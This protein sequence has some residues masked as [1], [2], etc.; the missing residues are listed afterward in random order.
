MFL[1]FECLACFYGDYG[2]YAFGLC[3]RPLHKASVLSAD[4]GLSAR[5]PW[6]KEALTPRWITL[7]ACS[8]NEVHSLAKK[9]NDK[10]VSPLQFMPDTVQRRGPASAVDF[11]CR[12]ELESNQSASNAQQVGKKIV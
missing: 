11:C 9:E 6:R 4:A 8:L 5:C 1:R 3:V 7:Q 10:H 2:L 12:T